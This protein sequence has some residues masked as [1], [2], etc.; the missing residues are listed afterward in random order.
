MVSNDTLAAICVSCGLH[1]HLLF[2]SHQLFN[3][4][5]QY[6]SQIKQKAEEEYR[7]AEENHRPPGQFWVG[8]EPP[9]VRN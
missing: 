5:Q 9:K 6:A 7:D 1:E 8:V 3:Q 4:I 2:E